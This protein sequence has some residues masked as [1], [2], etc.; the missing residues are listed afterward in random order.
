MVFKNLSRFKKHSIFQFK[1]GSCC[2]NLI[3]LKKFRQHLVRNR[4]DQNLNLYRLEASI[5][6]GIDLN[7]PH[8]SLPNLI[9][10]NTNMIND[11]KLTGCYLNVTPII[12]RYLGN[13][14]TCAA[15][16]YML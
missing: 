5:N 1:Q 12:S 9:V 7:V 15:L 8:N 11:S 2:R 14:K 13:S 3:G 6:Q 10:P 4:L 16:R